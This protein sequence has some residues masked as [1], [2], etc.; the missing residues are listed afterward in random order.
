MDKLVYLEYAAAGII[1]YWLINSDYKDT[2]GG[3]VEIS[4]S[5]N[6]WRKGNIYVIA[7]ICCQGNEHVNHFIISDYA[8][9]PITTRLA[10]LSS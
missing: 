4:T 2:I 10:F 7:Y 9:L 8:E 6:S 5:L 1:R 3:R